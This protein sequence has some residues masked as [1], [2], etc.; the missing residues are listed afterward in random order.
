MLIQSFILIIKG[1]I[2]MKFFKLLSLLSVLILVQGHAIAVFTGH[3]DSAIEGF[4]GGPTNTQDPMPPTGFLTEQTVSLQVP[5][6]TVTA[7]I[8]PSKKVTK[9]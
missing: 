6:H 7:K 4:A 5:A 1:G 3:G 9:K 2:I 8:V